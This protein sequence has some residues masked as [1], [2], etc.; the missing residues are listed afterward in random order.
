MKNSEI[1][2]INFGFLFTQ[3]EFLELGLITEKQLIDGRYVEQRK[4]PKSWNNNKYIFSIETR[5]EHELNGYPHFHIKTKNGEIN[6]R[7]YFDGEICDNLSNTIK[8]KNIFKLIKIFCLNEK[9]RQ[10]MIDI[11]IK[12]VIPAN[13]NNIFTFNFNVENPTFSPK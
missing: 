8:D 2:E 11:W 1:L 3:L 9:N 12:E 10:L 4:Q 6:S 7:F 13:S 5:N